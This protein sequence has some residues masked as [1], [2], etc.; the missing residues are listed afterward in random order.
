META[1]RLHARLGDVLLNALESPSVKVVHCDCDDVCQGH[2]VVLF[3]EAKYIAEA[4]K[5]LQNNGINSIPTEENI[6]GRVAKAAGLPFPVAEPHELPA[7][8]E[9]GVRS[10]ILPFGRKEAP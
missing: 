10:K 9:G 4:I 5:W 8:G 1:E 7:H 2:E 3:P 6:A